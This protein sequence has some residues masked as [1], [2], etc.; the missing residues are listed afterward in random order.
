[1]Q[2]LKLTKKYEKYPEYK[3]S[4]VEWLG[5]IPSSWNAQKIVSIFEFSNQKVTEETHEPLSV[6]YDG[7]KKQ[8]E[9]AAKVAE[10]SLRK[11]VK[12]G[13]IAINGR[14][15]RKG[16]VGMSEY[17][18]G[19]SLVYNVLRKRDKTIDSKYFHY[20]FRS[21]LFSEE[22]YRWGRGIV[23]DLWT[24]RESEMKKIYV[25]LPNP[26]EQTKIAK[27]LDEKTSYI[28]QL[29][30][31]K[32]KL[33]ELLREK[34]TSVINN[35]V[36]KGLN[37]KVELVESSIIW[38][39]KMPKGWKLD[40]IK[41][42][43][44]MNKRTLSEST[45][46]NFSFKYFDIGSVDEE[47]ISNIESEITFG[48]APSRARRIVSVGDSI[49]ATVR[50]YLKAIAYFDKLDTDTIASTGFAVLTPKNELIPK[51]LF[52]YLQSDRFINQVIIKSKGIGYPAI[53]PF[54]LGSLEIIYPDK[55]IQQSIIM[56]LDENIEKFNSIIERA[57]RSIK[58]LSEFKYSLVSNVVTGKIKV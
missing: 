13:D 14:S 37:Q 10:G 21:K 3:D 33:I 35:A 29:I 30:C 16:A 6:T 1:M 36:T 5:K 54:D 46:P 39:G 34:R 45:N 23:D 15:D 24:T 25:S 28:D 40:K 42:V 44:F 53:T 26:Q 32:Q 41:R 11:L 27:Y 17:E 18:G 7:I 57:E 20:L 50:T 31:K 48:K 49:I 52:Y 55:N 12:I 2:A 58:L 38:I 19:V 4:G 9:N 22:F 43:A 56:N 8:I 47:E 51:Y